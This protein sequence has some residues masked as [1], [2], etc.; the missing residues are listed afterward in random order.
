M[1][2]WR[3]QYGNS[4]GRNVQFNSLNYKEGIFKY[5]NN[6]LYHKNDNLRTVLGI[7]TNEPFSRLSFGNGKRK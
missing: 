4:I 6:K 7:G 2:N 1:S 5:N 3:N